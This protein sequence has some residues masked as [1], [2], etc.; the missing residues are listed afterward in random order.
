MAGN[1]WEWVADWY[2]QDYYQN[3]PQKD[4]PGPEEGTS[5]VLRGGNWYYKAYYMRATYRFN[6]RPEK[7]KVWQG[8]RCAGD[9][10]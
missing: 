5:R 10:T 3:S 1:V 4:P 8:F 7:F 2:A 6:E 9:S